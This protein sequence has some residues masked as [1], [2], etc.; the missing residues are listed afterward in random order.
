[1][2][3]HQPRPLRTLAALLLAGLA[4][5]ATGVLQ[6]A[7][8]VASNLI[9]SE[10]FAYPV[11]ST[12]PDPDG[13]LNAGKGLPAFN[14]GGTPSGTGL[15]GAWG[16]S[17][18]VVTG[19]TYTQGTK[20]LVTSGGAGRVNNDTWGTSMPGVYRDMTVDPFLAQRIGG[21]KYG[22]FGVS[23]TSLY[24]SFLAQTSSAT[25]KAFRLNF[26]YSAGSDFFYVGNTATGWSLHGTP[27]TSAPLALDTPTL[28]V[29][30]FDFGTTG[31]ASTNVS[32][33]I[34]P[35]LDQTLGTPNATK[36][37]IRF[38]GFGP[39][40]TQSTVA[41]AMTIDELR[42]GTTVESV[43]PHTTSGGSGNTDIP[44][45]NSGF[46]D[47]ASQTPNDWSSLGTLAADYTEG[48][49]ARS[50]THHLSH[51]LQGRAYQIYTYRTIT[52]LTPGTYTVKAWTRNSGG[53]TLTEM[54]VRNHGGANL[55]VPLPVSSR[56]NPVYAENV[57]ANVQVNNGQI[58]I[59]FYSD[60]NGKTDQ[61]ITVDDVTLT[62]SNP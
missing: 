33:W 44:F 41:N 4:A 51:W 2:K 47:D 16:T 35:P 55:S 29:M 48:W 39:F 3:T 18:N 26:K 50:G 30:R 5:H 21:T 60:A 9:I 28:M 14:Q 6:A 57:I 49:Q 12:N 34:N 8:T 10:P 27:A 11:P 7:E 40:Q 37:G 53:Q 61:W 36:S 58:E 22:N 25:A 38:D 43:T 15:N 32:L 54:R 17:M 59:G 62:R 1:M 45:S 52:G 31:T 56:P 19:L 13:G 46:E 20:T 42:I 24:V 23:S